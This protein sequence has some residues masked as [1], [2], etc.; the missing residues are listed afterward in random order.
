MSIVCFTLSLCT[1]SYLHLLSFTCTFF[2][3]VQFSYLWPSETIVPAIA[4]PVTPAWIVEA[5]VKPCHASPV[6]WSIG[7]EMPQQIL[8]MRI[9]PSH[10]TNRTEH[11]DDLLTWQC[12]DG[13]KAWY[14]NTRQDYPQVYRKYSLPLLSGLNKLLYKE[15]GQEKS[16]PRLPHAFQP[17]IYIQSS[18][19]HY[20][21]VA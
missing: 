8:T 12:S 20:I 11:S 5:G 9:K 17:T 18:W 19:L 6:N 7:W 2:F 14:K 1:F 3:H 13:S 10:S 4:P 15:P 16:L 21:I